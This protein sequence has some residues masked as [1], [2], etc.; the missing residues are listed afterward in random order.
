MT[1]RGERLET[2]KK[3]RATGEQLLTDAHHDTMHAEVRLAYRD[4]DEAGLWLNQENVD[5]RPSILAIV[6]LATNAA[7]HRL[8]TIQEALNTHGP[9]AMFLHPR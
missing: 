4:L 1:P 9:N 7:A 3:C 6:D 8:K 2:I 5:D